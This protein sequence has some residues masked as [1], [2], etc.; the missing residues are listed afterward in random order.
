MSEPAAAVPGP[1]AFREARWW[2]VAAST[3]TPA[4]SSTS[5]RCR[6]R[7]RGDTLYAFGILVLEIHGFTC[8]RW[9]AHQLIDIGHVYERHAVDRDRRPLLSRNRFDLLHHTRGYFRLGIG[10][11]VLQIF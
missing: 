4:S 3:S 9:I 11:G 1:R 5:T 7:R 10:H 8:K 2:R 6:T